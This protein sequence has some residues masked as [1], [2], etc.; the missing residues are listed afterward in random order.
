MAAAGGAEPG[1]ALAMG[2]NLHSQSSG[3][4]KPALTRKGASSSCASPSCAQ[5]PLSQSHSKTKLPALGSPG[6]LCLSQVPPLGVP[7]K[8]KADSCWKGD[9]EGENFPG[10]F[11]AGVPKVWSLSLGVKTGH[12][13]PHLIELG[14]AEQ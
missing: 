10:G 8:A 9:P 13:I 4:V 5:L 11:Q 2:M 1:T 6:L 14:F 12:E 7:S 3:L